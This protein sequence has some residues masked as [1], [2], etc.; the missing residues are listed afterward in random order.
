MSWFSRVK[1][2]LSLGDKRETADTLWL[3]CKSCEEMVFVQ[4]YRDNQSVCPRC[5]HHGRI[6]AR[7]R[8]EALFDADSWQILDSPAVKD[9][10]L[11][12]RDSKRYTDRRAGF[13]LYGRLYGHG[14]GQCFYRWC[15]GRHCQ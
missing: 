8:F 15:T 14:G 12:F 9:D 13:C 7:A 11:K 6:G 1:N 2:S 5:G 4:E 10:P 3:K